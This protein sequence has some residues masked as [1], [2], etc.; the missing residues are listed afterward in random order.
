MRC[1]W[2][3]N[4]EGIKP[5]AQ[6]M[7][8]RDKCIGCSSCVEI[9]PENACTLTPD[10]IVTDE[11]LCTVC[12]KCAD[13]CPTKAMEVS[14]RIV[15]VN[16]IVEAVEKER[17]FFDQSGGGVTFSGGEPLAQSEFL[18]TLLEEMGSRSIHR[19]VDTTGFANTETLLKVAE[20]T[21]HFLYDLKMMDSKRHKKWTGVPNEQI[22]KNLEILSATGAA[23]NIRIPLIKGVNADRENIDQSVKFIADLKG[24]PKTVNLLPYHNIAEGKYGRLGEDFNDQGMQE[25][26][27]E[28]VEKIA[29][30]F[31]NAEIKVIIGG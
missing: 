10:G 23:I 12:G 27:K 9:C 21:D 11:D 17:V 3:H 31:H 8:N 28:E 5:Q 2:C 22:L 16:D 30:Q 1:V 15:T 25:P 29:D 14:G 4:P 13:V 19:V 7:Y 26:S 20:K 18:L 6:K 24:P